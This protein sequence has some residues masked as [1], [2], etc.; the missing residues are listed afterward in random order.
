MFLKRGDVK[1]TVLS[2][3]IRFAEALTTGRYAD[4]RSLL[5]SDLQRSCSEEQLRLQY[6]QMTAYSSESA[7]PDGHTLFI[8]NWPAKTTGDLGWLYVS[9]SGSGFA[10]AVTVVVTDERGTPKIRD[11]EWGRP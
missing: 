10:E 9:I 7:M 8:E 2:T 11:I 4:A 3:G 6:E 1:D 5:T